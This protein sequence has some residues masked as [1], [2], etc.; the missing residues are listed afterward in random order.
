M[1]SGNKGHLSSEEEPVIF[2]IFAGRIWLEIGPN[3][4]VD[5]HAVESFLT[6]WELNST[7]VIIKIVFQNLEVQLE[8]ELFMLG[9]DG[10]VLEPDCFVGISKVNGHLG[11]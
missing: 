6:S 8:I 3:G 10:E 1:L 5:E 4:E 7:F 11:V 2:Q 9:S